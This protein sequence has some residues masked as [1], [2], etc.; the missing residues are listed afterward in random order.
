MSVGRGRGGDTKGKKGNKEEE[1]QGVEREVEMGKKEEEMAEGK[2]KVPLRLLVHFLRL[3][4]R[5][6]VHESTVNIHP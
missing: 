2:K 5:Q 3:L 4:S 1:C 6:L